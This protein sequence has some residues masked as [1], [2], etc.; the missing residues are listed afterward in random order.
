MDFTTLEEIRN[1]EK[2]N[3][4]IF[5]SSPMLFGVSNC[6]IMRW[7][8]NYLIVG[9]HVHTVKSLL[10]DPLKSDLPPNSGQ[11]ACPQCVR[12]SEGLLYCHIDEL[13]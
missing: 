4:V 3:T 5:A 8:M 9:S 2:R 1:L 13:N 10:T 12:F 11:T 6:N 7:F